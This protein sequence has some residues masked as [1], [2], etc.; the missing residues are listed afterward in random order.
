MANF[1]NIIVFLSEKYNN[2]TPP[3]NSRRFH[4]SII[5]HTN[6]SVVSLIYIRNTPGK[7][8]R[9]RN[10][11]AKKT[12]AP[13]RE[14]KRWR[15]N[16]SNTGQFLR[17]CAFA[18]FFCQVGPFTFQTALAE[19]ETASR[20]GIYGDKRS[21]TSSMILRSY[22]NV[23]EQTKSNRAL[24]TFFVVNSNS[25]FRGNPTVMLAYRFLYVADRPRPVE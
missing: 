24:L 3:H 16:G 18:C 10:L 9:I 23:A 2:V 6:H 8:D 25:R 4:K 14:C 19:R 5:A 7:I 20:K 13:V 11:F 22:Q 17:C 21:V 1:F 12:P 15:L